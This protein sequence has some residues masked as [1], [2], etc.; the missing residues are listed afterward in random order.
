MGIFD[1]LLEY[2]NQNDE[3]FMRGL[4]KSLIKFVED[5]HNY[6]EFVGDM[7]FINFYAQVLFNVLKIGKDQQEYMELLTTYLYTHEV[8]VYE[9]IKKALSKSVLVEDKSLYP[10]GFLLL[11][12][13]L[14][15]KLCSKILSTF[16]SSSEDV[17]TL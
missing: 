11:I 2:L 6:S 17:D 12:I 14:G 1:D 16:K 7:N 10:R 4:V 3:K 13:K 5:P 9:N 15:Q 8:L